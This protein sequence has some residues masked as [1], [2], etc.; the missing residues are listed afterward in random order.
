MAPPQNPH[1][2]LFRAVFQVPRYAAGLLRIVLPPEVLAVL[3]PD[4][5]EVL[6][7]SHVGAELRGTTSDLV[8]RVARRDTARNPDDAGAFVC[9]AIEHQSRDERF[10]LLRQLQYEGQLWSEWLR[11]HPGAMSLPPIVPV[12]V[13]T[14]MRA[15]HSPTSFLGLLALPEPPLDAAL[16][17][18]LPDFHLVLEDLATDPLERLRR[19]GT[20]PVSETTLE[21]LQNAGSPG[22]EALFQH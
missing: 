19:A 9:V 16:R 12:V 2:A 22:A 21:V 5:V 1:D 20:E 17:P 4:A 15:W 7:P 11:A 3:D 13:H 14:G 18:F 10:M 8:L 6:A